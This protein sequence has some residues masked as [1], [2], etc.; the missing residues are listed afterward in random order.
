M[1]PPYARQTQTQLTVE[2]IESEHAVE[3]T[4]QDALR[5]RRESV[6]TVSISFGIAPLH[7]T[8]PLLMTLYMETV[9][10]IAGS[11]HFRDQPQFAYPPGLAL[12]RPLAGTRQKDEL[13][14]INFRRD[15]PVYETQRSQQCA[16]N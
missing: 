6:G 1:I 10:V 7:R 11:T 8:E 2:R 14:E 9:V 15:V 16:P 3:A 4:G 13:G 12:Q 5:V